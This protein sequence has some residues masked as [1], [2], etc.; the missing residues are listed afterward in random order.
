MKN[1]KHN[2]GL[3]KVLPLVVVA[4][5]STGAADRLSE[6]VKQYDATA[7]TTPSFMYMGADSL[8]YLANVPQLDSA[9]NPKMTASVALLFPMGTSQD[10]VKKY[11]DAILSS[12]DKIG[13]KIVP[14]Y[15]D[16][17]KNLKDS[18]YMMTQLKQLGFNPKVPE[19][20]TSIRPGK[21]PEIGRTVEDQTNAIWYTLN[22]KEIAG[23][24]YMRNNGFRM[25]VSKNGK[26]IINGYNH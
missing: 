10:T 21:Q 12:G 7:K 15:V 9:K 19:L 25:V 17:T 22:G 3:Y 24:N 5:A 6:V 13:K 11:T 20:T 26:R 23:K 18:T 4:A 8:F 14:L 2:S 16:T 1:E